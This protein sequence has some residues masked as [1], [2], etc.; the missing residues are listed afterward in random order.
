MSFA[1]QCP[2]TIITWKFAE[3]LVHNCANSVDLWLGPLWVHLDPPFGDTAPLPSTDG[4]VLSPNLPEAGSAPL[5][6]DLDLWSR[7]GKSSDWVLTSGCPQAA[8]LFLACCPPGL[9]AGLVAQMVKNL[10]AMQ[11]TWVEP[12]V[13]KILWRS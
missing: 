8:A 2:Q 7:G 3:E 4:P 11:E 6:G 1:P 9:G 12:W 5:H 10:P 13:R